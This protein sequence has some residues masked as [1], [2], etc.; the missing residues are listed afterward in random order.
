[1]GVVDFIKKQVFRQGLQLK[2]ILSAKLLTTNADGDIIETDA[3]GITINPDVVVL[4]KEYTDAQAA[5]LPI[6][7]LFYN[8]DQR[9]WIL[10]KSTE[11]LCNLGEENTQL[12]K[13]GDN[14]THL[15]GQV[16]YFSSGNGKLPVVSLANASN[17]LTSYSIAIAT[18]T[19][20]NTESKTGYYCS[21]GTV[22]TVPIS[23][24][25]Q[26]GENDDL[27]VE[28]VSL[29]MSA[30]N[31]GRMTTVRPTAPNNAVRIGYITDRSGAN[32][33][34]FVHIDTGHEFSELH[35]VNLNTEYTTPIENDYFTIFN[36]TSGI[37]NK[38]TYT[39]FKNWLNTIYEQIINKDAN[40]GYVGL[41][42]FKIN[43]KNVAN[44]F[45]SYL[46]NSNTASRT[47]TFP[48]KN[49]TVAGTIDL[50]LTKVGTGQTYTKISEA[51]TAGEKRL[52]VVSSITEVT[53]IVLSD[54]VYIDSTTVNNVVTMGSV[55]ANPYIISGSGSIINNL[56]IKSQARTTVA[57]MLTCTNTTFNNCILDNSLVTTNNIAIIGGNNKCTFKFCTF[58]AGNSTTSGMTGT[59]TYINCTL[60]G[61]GTNCINA[62][63]VQNSK[64][65]DL[66]ING[67]VAPDQTIYGATIE[68][69]KS[70]ISNINI[71]NLSTTKL[72]R[73]NANVT[74]YG[75]GS[76]FDSSIKANLA[77]SSCYNTTISDPM[78]VNNC[79]FENCTFT[80]T[81]TAGTNAIFMNCVFNDTLT[82]NGSNVVVI[83]CKFV[84]G[85]TSGSAVKN[86]I[87]K[88]NYIGSFAGIGSTNYT[89]ANMSNFTNS[90]IKDNYTEAAITEN[91]NN[92]FYNNNL[93]T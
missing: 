27:W 5:A 19:V 66:T 15:N 21:F 56:T 85:I 31:D 4:N 89:I 48:D 54:G 81:V 77:N 14:Q 92:D 13:I 91:T 20:L 58:K 76:I 57:N 71:T 67:T 22:N 72:Y 63:I 44:T 28:G 82:I 41:T 33:T 7:S 45:T 34:I 38:F 9:S 59:A 68:G 17:E 40:N 43:F 32:V 84:K 35:D 69:L 73:I 29:Y 61:G 65:V 87:I 70:S 2:N 49:L 93:H 53:D 64:V 11:H 25:I 90:I 51:I 3:N 55:I 10:K 79:R 12:M 8:S 16:V 37:W 78:S 26:G 83:N 24:V 6:G 88:G 80:S 30:T 39:A 75:G 46:T 52:L 36:F 50:S 23:N 62:F 74:V 60:T 86:V 42:L 47:Y 1:M 18:E